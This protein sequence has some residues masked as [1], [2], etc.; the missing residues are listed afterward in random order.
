MR[1][2]IHAGQ[3]LATRT[4]NEDGAAIVFIAVSLVA[5]LAMTAFVI[6]FGRIWQERRELQVGAEA[7]AFAI[8]EDC[9]RNQCPLGYDAT[10]V[11]DWYADA[12][13]TDGAANVPWVDLNLPAQTVEVA[14]QTETVTGQ[15]SLDMMFARTV[16]IDTFEVGASAK[17]QW[18]APISATTIPLIVSLCEWDNAGGN[19]N[20]LPSYPSQV[21]SLT[22]S[23]MVQFTFHS[24]T[25]TEPCNAS[26]GFD[27]DQD[28]LLPGGFG[29][30]GATNDCTSL[31]TEALWV[32]ADPGS[33]P[34]TGCSAAE[35]KSLMFD[36]PVNIPFFHD[37]D[38]IDGVQGQGNNG[39]YLVAGSGAFIVAGY[40]F[41]GQFKEYQWP[42]LDLP[43]TGNTRCLAGWFVEYTDI[44]GSGD[45]GGTDFGVTVIK[46]IG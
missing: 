43:C 21:G 5:L 27:S 8:G 18:G 28:G 39:R 14:T 24:T 42:L 17:V 33:S 40:N 6:D 1:W 32:T 2:L 29:W 36:A 19:S 46:L 34:S 13:A 9:A 15:N 30:I 44:G 23:N 25:E 37:E 4:R 12:N 20:T 16:G 11:A 10:G 7:A 41:G 3:R 45:L 22:L 31:V 35:L 38:G 26:P